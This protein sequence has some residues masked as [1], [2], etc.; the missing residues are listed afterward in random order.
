MNRL[1]AWLGRLRQD[2]R[3]LWYEAKI[4]SLYGE[5]DNSQVFHEW[6][7]LERDRLIGG[8][9][10]IRSR[11]HDAVTRRQINELL[12]KYD[13]QSPGRRS[14]WSKIVPTPLDGFPNW[15]PGSDRG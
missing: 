12:R 4:A 5:L 2:K 9:R 15:Y 11:T 13:C 6:T 7:R 3:V 1:F 8:L 14:F 10:G